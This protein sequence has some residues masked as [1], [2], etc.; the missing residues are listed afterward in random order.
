MNEIFLQ[1]MNTQPHHKIITLLDELYY[2]ISKQTTN[3]QLQY[4]NQKANIYSKR[5]TYQDICFSKDSFW[6]RRVNVR[7]ILPNEIVLDIDPQKGETSENLKK[8]AILGIAPEVI[9]KVNSR[10]IVIRVFDSGSRGIHLHIF[11]KL[12]LYLPQH[13]RNFIRRFFCEKFN[14]D[15]QKTTEQVMIAL[16]FANHFKT[17][18][19]KKLL[20][21]VDIWD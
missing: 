12:M 1:A 6:L 14:A 7:S 20:E 9:R 8:R 2:R 19:T 21:E 13:K 10:G 18:K 3:F 4:L 15:L 5:R 11:S 16:E 17:M